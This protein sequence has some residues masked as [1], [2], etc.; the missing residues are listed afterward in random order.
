MLR[1]L[2]VT[3]V[4]AGCGEPARPPSLAPPTTDVVL[5]P[6]D[7]VSV[8][9]D[10]PAPDVLDAGATPTDLGASDATPSNFDVDLSRPYPAGPVGIN[11]GNV[12]STFTL[13]DC[14]G[15]PYAFAGPEFQRSRATVLAVFT[16]TCPSCAADARA[17]ATLANEVRGRGVRVV[18]VLIEGS[19]PMEIPSATFCAQWRSTAGATHP[20]LIDAVRSQSYLSPT[21]AWPVV[22]VIDAGGYIRGRYAAQPDWAAQARNQLAT[23]A[24]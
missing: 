11:P 14:A 3:G 17:L 13:P 15:Q 2:A 5:A 20:V 16:G 10:I 9:V 1:A 4:I 19:A 21:Q 12:P 7:R 22:L 8:P 24:P 6:V 18:A 23:L